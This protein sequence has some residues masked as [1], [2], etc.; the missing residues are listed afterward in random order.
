MNYKY[1]KEQNRLYKVSK[2]NNGSLTVVRNSNGKVIFETDLKFLIFAD[3][4]LQLT[5]SLTSIHVYGLGEHRDVFRKEAKWNKYVMFN[6]GDGPAVSGSSGEPLYGTQ[7]FHMCVE[8]LSGNSNGMLMFNSNPMEVALQ[9]KPGL[10][11]RTIGG[12][13]DVFIMVGPSPND[14]IRQYSHLVGLPHLPPFWSLGFQLCRYGYGSSDNTEK[15]FQRNID[16]GIPIEVQWNDID[17]M[18]K[19]QFHL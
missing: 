10:T 13:L 8:D 14:I 4:Y 18:E 1:L 19:Q 12:V 16:A 15:T 7:P 5:T 2:S 9:P 11:L 6:S 3:E 17:F